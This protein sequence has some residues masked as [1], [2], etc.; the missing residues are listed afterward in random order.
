[1][2]FLRILI[3]FV[4]E[5][6][7]FLYILENVFHLERRNSRLGL[8]TSALLT[9]GWAICIL[10]FQSL[11][12]Y[13]FIILAVTFL[14]FRE[15]WYLLLC[16]TGV[17]SL[18]LNILSNTALYVFH[19]F[20]GKE[21]A[22]VHFV[23]SLTSVMVLLIGAFILK[24]RHISVQEQIHSIHRKSYCLIVLVTII[25]FFLSSVSSLLFYQNLNKL[26]RYLLVLAIFI[27]IVMSITLL[28]LYF[29]LQHYH[30]LL[31]ETN[32]VNK[33][34]L[35]LEIQHYKEMQE[36]TMTLRSF[37]HDYNYHVTAMQGLAVKEDWIGLKKYIASLS[38]T[39][40]Q[41]YYIS[42]NHP[43]ADAIVNYFYEC[44]S[45]NTDFQLDGKFPENV[46]FDDVDLCIILSN[47]LKN[48]VEAIAKLPQTFRK[49]LYIS[50]YADEQYMSILVENT[51]TPYQDDFFNHLGTTKIDTINH[52]LG[53][54]NVKRVVDKY[55][56]KL[57]LQY[58]DETF[59]TTVLL[60]HIKG[61][62]LYT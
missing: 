54:K 8:T 17:F 28:L 1:M 60:Y 23:L 13:T 24:R 57:D 30:T 33:K 9:I 61:V 6:F 52:G 12:P 11:V 44:L 4:A 39:K 27:M 40:E 29:R 16:C 56:G 5:L 36:K 42:T 34:M 18:M 41:L 2:I 55:E 19:I 32:A 35:E 49:K 62:H 20:T 15:K 46:F 21:T 37:R 43:V 58:L 48:A 7:T 59:T 10:L 3:L 50:L 25:D 31:K 38:N 26:G 14:L 45:D 22:F 47:L 51:S 53:L